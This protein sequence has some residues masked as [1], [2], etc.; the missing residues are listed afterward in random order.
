MRDDCN[1]NDERRVIRVQE[2]SNERTQERGS[3]LRVQSFKNSSLSK[4]IVEN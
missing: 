1:N 3:D 2:R 4:T